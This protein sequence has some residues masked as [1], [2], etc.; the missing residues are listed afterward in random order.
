MFKFK[1]LFVCL[2]LSTILLS[3]YV[4]AAIETN[5]PV[6]TSIDDSMATS[7]SVSTINED[8]Y[9]TNTATYTFSDIINGN[10]FASAQK[11]VINPRNNGGVVNGNL[12]LISSEVAIE[13]DVTYSDSKDKNGN[14]IINSVNSNS[15]I[16]GNVYVLSD[17]FT[18]ESGSVIYGDLYVLSSSKISIEPNAIVNGNVFIIA[19][20]V[21]LNGQ[22]KGSAYIKAENFLMNYY[23]YI[24]RDLFLNSSSATLDGIIYRNAFLTVA[25]DLETKTD[26]KV[27]QN[28]SITYAN[29]L[30]FSGTVVGNASIN[31]K[32][33]SFKNDENITCSIRGNLNY[34]TQSNFD[35]PTG[36]V[37]G[38][39]STEKFV[40][41]SSKEFSFSSLV[42]GLIILLVY[43][44]AIV[45]IAKKFAANA[46][47][48]LP[49]L[50]LANVLKSLGIGFVSMFAIFIIFIALCLSGI[51]TSLAFCFALAYMFV[52]SL[53]VPFILLTIANAIKL[54]INEY[55]KLLIVAV[56][57]YL[58]KLIPIVSSLVSFIIVLVGIG[59]IILAIFKRNN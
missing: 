39:V 25:E 51:G 2:A 55:L 33:M 30:T 27:S 5:E 21:N 18:L 8:K 15:V 12:F 46:L 43:V 53:S 37:A 48:K 36:V 3:S 44:F 6:V 57:L 45:W 23:A 34:A 4:F 54:N 19:S 28:L 56:I 11:F 1:K 10:I 40:E 17:S 26:F 22:I 38:T 7:S 31:A 20:E 50:N 24:E 29:N 42:L 32:Q 14:F 41:N 58:L 35:V 16:N 52:V 49:E 59:Q 13:S 47:K 9:I